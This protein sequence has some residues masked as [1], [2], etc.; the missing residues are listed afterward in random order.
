MTGVVTID[1]KLLNTLRW[2][3]DQTQKVLFIRL[4]FE[5][6]DSLFAYMGEL[7]FQG[8]WSIG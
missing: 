2:R 1:T 3:V 8:Q 5:L 4:K 7:S 6:A